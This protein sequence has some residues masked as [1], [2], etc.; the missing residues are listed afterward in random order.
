MKTTAIIVFLISSVG[1]QAQERKGKP[2]AKEWQ[3]TY[4]YS[5]FGSYYYGYYNGLGAT[6]MGLEI[7]TKGKAFDITTW[8]HDR[9]GAG[10]G[11]AFGNKSEFGLSFI[12][13]YALTPTWQVNVAPV[14]RFVPASPEKDKHLKA[15]IDLDVIFYQWK[16]IGLKAGYSSTSQYSLGA[17]FRISNYIFER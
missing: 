4:Y 3:K 2:I 14:V 16:N 11:F 15:G 12:F 8:F 1:L 17:N 5:Y 7:G 9:Y 13:A 10:M 6:D